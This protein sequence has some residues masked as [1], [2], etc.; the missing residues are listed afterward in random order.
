M[1]LNLSAWKRV[2]DAKDH[3]VFR[4]EQGHE[5]KV[6]KGALSPGMRKQLDAI[7]MADGGVTAP[8]DKAWTQKDKEDFSKGATSGGTSGPD[9][10]SNL[11]SGLGMAEGGTAEQSGPTKDEQVDTNNT[12]GEPT[13]ADAASSFAAKYGRLPTKKDV[14][15]TEGIQPGFARGGAVKKLA[16]GTPDNPVS[17]DLKFGE[18]EPVETMGAGDAPPQPSAEDSSP[19]P[20]VAP[21]GDTAQPPGLMYRVGQDIGDLASAPRRAAGA[22]LGAAAPYAGQFIRGMTGASPTGD[23]TEPAA[24]QSQPNAQQS[25]ANTSAA[26]D[27]AAA[28][29]DALQAYMQKAAEGY[30]TEINGQIAK[31]RAAGIISDNQ[32]DVLN[33]AGNSRAAI[34]NNMIQNFNGISK[35]IHDARDDINNNLV[36][37][38]KYWDNHSKIAT[39]IGLII[40]GF[41]PTSRPNAAL[42]FLNTQ[43]NRDLESQKATLGAKESLLSHTMN[44]YGHLNDAVTM[45]NVF[46]HDQ[47]INDL[48]AAAAKQGTPM[49]KANA[50]LAIGPLQRQQAALTSQL[51]LNSAQRNT[52][53]TL[54]LIHKIQALRMINPEM[55]KDLESRYVQMPGGQERLGLTPDDAK[56]L[57]EQVGT[58]Q[59]IMNQLDQ[60]DSLGPSA[61]VP[62]SPSA[63]QAAAIRAQLIPMINENAGLKR[64]SEADIHNLSE[65]I[66]DP[67]SFSNYIGGQ[68]RSNVL[69]NNILTKLL[70]SA[71]V[72]LEGGYQ[73]PVS[74]QQAAQPQ[75]KM[76]G[77]KKWMRGPDGKAIEV[78]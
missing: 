36:S 44:M 76:S 37:P 17:T 46:Q 27:Q 61:M 34:W 65:S 53:Q 1:K 3:S 41:N 66:R 25:Q 33:K 50:A 21:A 35:E 23:F 29:P 74:Q 54:P 40:G 16:D 77:G 32:L 71:N 15:H 42:E 48:Q 6:A 60:L 26:G 19:T 75:Y 39:A 9:A 38:Q 18:G 20:D 12:P 72:H 10:W 55:A 5:L 7:K 22:L 51:A 69:R 67:H 13:S 45:A 11:K 56:V 62:G 64:L 73:A 30:D 28:T 31:A 24:A 58:V 8:A 52:P 43:M 2:Q 14:G 47:V 4:N 70:S 57:K 78:R 49:A 59:P 63:Q 68:A